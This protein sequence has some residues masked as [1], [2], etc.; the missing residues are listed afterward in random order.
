MSCRPVQG[1]PQVAIRS[2]I[3][4]RLDDADHRLTLPKKARGQECLDKVSFVFSCSA[5]ARSNPTTYGT[6]KYELMVVGLL[7]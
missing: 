5:I 3:V 4:R 6:V 7:R 1:V 2:Y